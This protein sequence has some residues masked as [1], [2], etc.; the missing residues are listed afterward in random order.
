LEAL[1]TPTVPT[2]GDPGAAAVA[3]VVASIAEPG[4]EELED[5]RRP[6]TAT[7]LVGF[8][9]QI[10]KDLAIDSVL[11]PSAVWVKSRKMQARRSHTASDQD[12]L[13]SFIFA[14]LGRVENAIRRGDLG[15]ALAS[16]LLPHERIDVGRR[17]DVRERP[18]RVLTEVSPDRTLP[19]RWVTDVDKPLALSQQFAVNRIL[20]GMTGPGGTISAVNGPPGTGKTTM[21]RDVTAAL[22]VERAARLASLT[23]P[24]EAFTQSEQGWSS[25]SG[26]YGVKALRSDLTGF[27][28]VVACAGNGAAEN[29]TR[30]FPSDGVI[31]KQWHEAARGI[32]Y[33][34]ELASIVLE[35]PDDG[36]QKPAWAA[37]SAVLG[38]MDNRTTFKERYWW[39]VR[40][41]EEERAQRHRRR[42]N[43]SGVGLHDILQGHEA[44]G[45]PIDW[46]TAVDR[47]KTVRDEVEKLVLIRS[48][49]AKSMPKAADAEARIN[50]LS[51]KLNE[52]NRRFSQAR[53]DASTC[54]DA[55]A[56]AEADAGR[57]R[58]DRAEH[59]RLQPKLWVTL[60]TRGR[61][62]RDWHATDR[63]LAAALNDATLARADARVAA[64]RA[65]RRAWTLEKA[66][67]DVTARLD[68]AR[69]DAQQ[70]AFTLAEAIVKW[71]RHV[72][73][74]DILGNPVQIELLA[75]W[76][77]AEL[78]GARTRLFLEALR[79]HKAFLLATAGTMRKN[80]RATFQLVGGS[81]PPDLDPEV[82]KAAW[83][84]LFLAV[85]VVSTT[86]ASFDKVFAHFGAEDL[87]WV[88]ID[89][90]G[91]AAPQC[92]V[93]PLWRARHA[94]IVGDPLQLEPVVTLAWTVQ[95][96]LRQYYGVAEEWLPGATSVQGVADRLAEHGTYLD[97]DSREGRQRGWVASPLRVH[98]RCDDPMFTLSNTIAYD[99]LMVFGTP[100]IDPETDPYHELPPSSW[101]D[102]RSP[103][104]VGKWIPEE[105]RRLV[106]AI[107]DLIHERGVDPAKIRVISPFR[108]VA[109]RCEQACLELLSRKSVGTVHTM[110]GK[111][112]DIIFL[113][114]GSGPQRP[115]A[116][117][118]A[119]EKPNLLNVAVSRARRRLYVIGSRELW[120]RQRYFSVLAQLPPPRSAGA[121]PPRT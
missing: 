88:F 112:A 117:E 49:A 121:Q 81:I 62:G 111:E 95:Q 107:K 47:F 53:L 105:G 35:L 102:V 72:P 59:A 5:V 14:D 114:L 33:F 44:S 120:S 25:E 82:A 24:D 94:A 63:K 99:G 103:E 28:I 34:A 17:I 31:D 7:D 55:V 85:P 87:G 6:L 3:G 75:P 78:A 74:P 36:S 68:Q 39:G 84:C 29:I 23:S 93:G 48:D 90:A 91:Q 10:A 119:A 116:R 58:S 100:P 42:P 8:T 97:M 83:R 54:H 27:E 1:G 104:A 37:I 64:E 92:A 86:F 41:E 26:S 98:R 67:E 65:D 96:A 9:E 22:V 15:A 16:Y 73:T 115:G 71:P 32:D 56:S 76:A 40:R 13:N 52:L 101:I 20:A 108:E 2:V 113:V 45:A 18:D 79:L 57:V 61:A 11:A 50:D 69:E 19:G 30:E 66:R 70:A 60:V 110:Q 89:E 77:D 80:L 43:R 109:E 46:R 12:F 118:W 51:V 38:K 106:G 4:I 21:L